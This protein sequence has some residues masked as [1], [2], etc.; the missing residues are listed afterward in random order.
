MRL[1]GW[2]GSWQGME[3]EISGV[4]VEGFLVRGAGVGRVVV[5]VVRFDGVSVGDLVR[6]G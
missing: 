1:A 5:G 4:P 3:R 2:G 6:W